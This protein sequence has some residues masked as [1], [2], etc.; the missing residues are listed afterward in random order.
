VTRR[1]GLLEQTWEWPT[2]AAVSVDGTCPDSDAAQAP[3][4]LIIC[5]NGMQG[6]RRSDYLS[7]ELRWYDNTTHTDMP[8]ADSAGPTAKLPRENTEP[9]YLN[10]YSPRE[11]CNNKRG[12][13]NSGGQYPSW[14]HPP[15][16]SEASGLRMCPSCQHLDNDG[17]SGNV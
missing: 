7:T 4:V 2:Q 12:E 15:S 14:T 3:T 9:T 8:T 16:L 10:F 1:V 6:F 5:A 11:G 17:D 13:Y